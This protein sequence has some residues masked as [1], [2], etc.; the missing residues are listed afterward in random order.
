MTFLLAACGRQP[1]FMSFQDLFSSIIF[2]VFPLLFIGQRAEP[3]HLSETTI[4]RIF[5]GN[6]S[7][8]LTLSEML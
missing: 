8:F 6:K 2:F 3:A 5:Y 7:I 1:I 4:N